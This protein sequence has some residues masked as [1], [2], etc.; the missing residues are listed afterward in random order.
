LFCQGT[1][2]A[3]P[4]DPH[5]LFV[6][7]QRSEESAFLSAPLGRHATVSNCP[8]LFN[9]RTVFTDRFIKEGF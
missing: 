6:I 1:A 8:L 5:L 9:S 2:L 3:V 4:K 7:P